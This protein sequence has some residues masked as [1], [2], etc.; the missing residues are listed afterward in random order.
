M[1][2]DRFGDKELIPIVKYG[3]ERLDLDYKG[4]INWHEWPRREKAELARD[5]MVLANSDIPGYIV[6]GATDLGGVVRSY[7]GL[8]DDQI[9]SFDPSKIADKVKR[10]ANPEVRFELYKPIVDGNRYVVIRVLPFQNVP[11]IC[12]D[13]YDDVLEEAAV[14]VRGEGARTIKV[15]SAEHMRRLVDR[16]IQISA[17]TLVD[18]I[19]RLVGASKEREAEAHSH[20]KSQIAEVRKQVGKDG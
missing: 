1:S 20:F 18:R 4:P 7:D 19:R 13:S 11:H 2:Y 8:S 12:I 9:K 14:Y 16:A 15:P 3:R 6:I 17:D 10:Y 5:M